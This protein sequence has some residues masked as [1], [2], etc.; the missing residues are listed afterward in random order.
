MILSF[1]N[2]G[3]FLSGACKVADLGGGFG[4]SNYV[5]RFH[6]PPPEGYLLKTTVE[7]MLRANIHNYEKHLNEEIQRPVMVNNKWKEIEI[8]FQIEGYN[9]TEM[10]LTI[11][12]YGK[13]FFL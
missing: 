10:S 12:N 3:M 11:G 8:N 5:R 7:I 4:F 13:P 9:N 1:S 6:S 2:V